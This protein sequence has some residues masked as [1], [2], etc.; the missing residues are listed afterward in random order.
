MAKKYNPARNMSH[1]QFTGTRLP[2]S[3]SPASRSSGKMSS[4]HGTGKSSPSKSLHNASNRIGHDCKGF[5]SGP[6][7][8]RPKKI[9]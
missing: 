3:H 2:T 4:A 1:A 6:V 9:D 7:V 5:K 8:V